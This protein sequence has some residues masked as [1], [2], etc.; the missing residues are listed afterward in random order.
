MSFVYVQSRLAMLL[1]IRFFA[2]FFLVLFTLN[3]SYS[4]DKLKVVVWNLEWFPGGSPRA[5]E[6]EKQVHR[7]AAA[8]DLKKLNP[9]ILIA[10]EV[11]NWKEFDALVRSVGLTTNVV[12]SFVSSYTGELWPQQVAIASRLPCRAVWAETFRPVI[13]TLPRG[14]VCAALE[15]P[16][17]DEV[18]MVYGVHLKSNRANNDKQ[19]QENY[20]KRDEGTIQILDHVAYMQRIVFKSSKIRGWIV[21]GDMN[22]NHDRIF[23]DHVVEKFVDAGFV[24]TWENVPKEKR[25]TWRGDGQFDPVTFD[26]I[27]VK[28]FGKLDATIL[29]TSKETSDHEAVSL[30]LSL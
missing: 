10:C 24:N 23:G 2:F 8:E 5:T 15:V 26:Y 1:S 7:K 12:S 3:T 25:M 6:E 20:D 30:T 9:D 21:G 18:L 22:T 14:F 17:T 16:E 13:P 27:F 29:E 19:A 28:G 11:Q 4:A